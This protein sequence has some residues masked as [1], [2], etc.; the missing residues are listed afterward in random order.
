LQ[1]IRFDMVH[2]AAYS[3]R[4]GTQAAKMLIDDVPL[5]A[6][7][8]RVEAVEKLQ[9]GIAGEINAQLVGTTI[10]ILVE[11]SDKGKWYG[12]TRGDKLVFFVSEKNYQNQ[13][14]NVKIT[15]SSPWSLTGTLA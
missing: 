11:G 14:V 4:S 1:E 15:R 13:L 2:V 9:T 12:R 7:K 8:S 6:K 5:S 10:E 3:Q